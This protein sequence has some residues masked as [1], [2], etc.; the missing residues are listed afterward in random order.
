MAINEREADEFASADKTC[1]GRAFIGC[2]TCAPDSFELVYWGYQCWGSI[3]EWRNLV[4]DG[5]QTQVLADSTAI[6]AS[7]LNHCST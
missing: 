7:V 3:A 1:E 6:A 5:T 4:T 2:F